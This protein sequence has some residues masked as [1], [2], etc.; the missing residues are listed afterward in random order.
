MFGFLIK[1]EVNDDAVKLKTFAEMAVKK[2][3]NVSFNEAKKIVESDFMESARYIDSNQCNFYYEE[4]PE[5]QFSLD[6]GLD[7]VPL[8]LSVFGKGKYAGFMLQA[9][10]GGDTWQCS[11]H[12]GIAYR[13]T[14][15]AKKLAQTMEK[16]F[17][18]R[19]FSKLMRQYGID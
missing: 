18:F 10:K 9:I 17:G 8:T 14:G 7:E 13:A 3:A 12:D 4:L 15:G 11:T 5:F 2:Y 19:D 1:G 16:K 6:R